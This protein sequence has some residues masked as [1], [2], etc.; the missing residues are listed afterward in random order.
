MDENLLSVCIIARNEEKMLAEC[1]ESV[2]TIA[3]EIILVDTGSTDATLKIAENYGCRILH[4]EWNNNFSDARNIALD[5]AQCEWILSIDCDERLLNPKDVLWTLSASKP[6]TGGYLVDVRSDAARA[7]GATDTY[8]SK[9]LRLFRNSPDVRFQGIIHEQVLESIIQLGLEIEHS[10]VKLY[11][12]GYNLSPEAMLS[13]QK[14]NLTLLDMAIQE[15]PT[16]AYAYINRAKTHLALGNITPADND[17]RSALHYAGKKSIVRPQALCYS[18]I[19]AFQ[20]GNYERAITQAKQALEIIPQQAM[21]HFILGEAYSALGRYT[22]AIENYTAMTFAQQSPGG[23]AQIA[24]EYH[25]PPEQIAFRLGRSYA[26]LQL[27][28]EAGE[29][30]KRGLKSNSH[31]LGCL[32]G[33]ANVMLRKQLYDEAEQYLQQAEKIAPERE[34]IRGFLAQIQVQ[35][36]TALPKI[37]KPPSDFYKKVNLSENTHKETPQKNTTK[38]PLLSLSMIVKNEAKNLA[39]CLES[40]ANIA[41]EIIILD[42]GSTDS[43]M[44]IARSFSAV[45]YEKEWTGDFAEARNESL[46]HCTGKWILYLDADE[47]LHEAAQTHLRPMLDAL[48][49]EIGA[50][51]CSIISPHR[52]SSGESEVHRGSYPRIFRNYGYPNMY[53]QGRVHEQITPSI[54]MLG[55]QLILSEVEILHLGYDQNREVMEQK[56]KRNYELLIEHVKEEPENS[57]AWF[58]LGQ[59]LG[60]MNLV[61]QSEQALKL[62][63]EFGTLSSTIGA[64]ASAALAQ[65]AGNSKRFNEALMWADDSLEKAPKQAYALHLKAY[66]LL[67]LGRAQEA[68]EA[69]LEVKRRIVA[70]HGVPH[71]G[72][73]IEIPEQAIEHGLTEARKLLE[74]Y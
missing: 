35:R 38:K 52:Q 6:V 56:V 18:A 43:T 22:E 20:S 24:G 58:Q 9:L 29:E 68:E 15:R 69:F 31:E 11:H 36:A 63:I 14:R 25:L 2:A 47:R 12:E 70:Q 51:V 62:A 5:V 26:A 72:F 4:Y 61:E 37:P 3:N 73:E 53:F 65:I 21:A 66:A 19:I 48:P 54:L 40:V 17:I 34:D 60:R 32:V 27:W 71:T 28:D 16:Y 42:T 45:V 50:V 55:G 30:F 13:K 44:D 7:D 64:S 59:T 39:G 1:L 46:K 33:I 74:K 8:S 57:Y 10:P 49:D 67:Y 41:D 23:L